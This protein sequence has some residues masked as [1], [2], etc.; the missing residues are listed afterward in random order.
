MIQ[1]FEPMFKN[2]EKRKLETVAYLF[3]NPN[4]CLLKD[5]MPCNTLMLA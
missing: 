4:F 3:M 5:I 2:Y 1:S